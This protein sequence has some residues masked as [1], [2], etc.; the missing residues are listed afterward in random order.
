[1]C[2]CDVMLACVSALN[3]VGN[4]KRQKVNG[5]LFAVLLVFGPEGK[6]YHH[7]LGFSLSLEL[8]LYELHSVL[9]SQLDSS[10]SKRTVQHSSSAALLFWC[11][12]LSGIATYCSSFPC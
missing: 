6:D 9:L 1:M 4:R 3:G 8:F 12:R 2:V 10:S 7:T 11:S 5:I